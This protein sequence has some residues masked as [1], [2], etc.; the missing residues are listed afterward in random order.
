[1]TGRWD[2]ELDENAI[3]YDI[4]IG[5]TQDAAHHLI[6]SGSVY[7]ELGKFDAVK[8]NIKKLKE[9]SD[10]FNDD[11]A[12]VI[13]YHLNAFFLKKIR[14]LDES[15]KVVDAGIRLSEKIGQRDRT[16]SLLGM[17]S[18]IQIM[19][20]DLSLAKELLDK[21]I[22]LISD[23]DIVSPLY[24]SSYLSSY[25]L[26]NL[27]RLEEAVRSNKD[28]I[29][30]K[31]KKEAFKS[32][33]RVIRNSTKVVSERSSAFLQMGRYYWL[34]G[35][36]SQALK[37]W[38]RSIKEG[39]RLGARPNLSRTYFEVGRRLLDPQS[40]YKELNGVEANVYL[41][42]ARALFEELGLERDLDELDRLAP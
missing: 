10:K 1:M 41:K 38:S 32:G 39:E 23:E 2:V 16:I 8:I 3:N 4:Q 25:F 21:A 11:S 5:A 14:K 27:A 40:K 7:L 33:K 34:I 31:Y 12:R 6:F 19:K 29:I 30:K 24:Y 42:K 18:Q 13:Y 35:G 15:S 36:R 17:K 26:Y 22:P 28:D 20:N 37:W 9:I